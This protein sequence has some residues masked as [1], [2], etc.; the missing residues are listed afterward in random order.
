MNFNRPVDL[1]SLREFDGEDLP[2]SE[3]DAQLIDEIWQ[4]FSD[5]PRPSGDL[6]MSRQ[7]YG[8]EGDIDGSLHGKDARSIPVDDIMDAE[9][10]LYNLTDA[11]LHHYLP[12]FMVAALLTRDYSIL[13]VYSIP[14]VLSPFTILY[15]TAATFEKR[16]CNYSEKQRRAIRDYLTLISLECEYQ[17]SVICDAIAAYW[18]YE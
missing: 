2:N 1:K 9:D 6:L 5:V 13:A 12:A 16:F 7:G 8:D 3:M 11:A 10:G 4:A 18:D 17:R 14:N 15:E